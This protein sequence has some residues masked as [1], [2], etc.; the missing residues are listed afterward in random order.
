MVA[1]N[2]KNDGR[3]RGQYWPTVIFARDCY[4]GSADMV[5]Y[6]HP[7]TVSAETP[8]TSLP[9]FPDDQIPYNA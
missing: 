4:G 3:Y 6:E 8:R 5:D 9:S 1:A 7:H 2:E